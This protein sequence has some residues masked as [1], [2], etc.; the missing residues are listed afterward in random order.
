MFDRDAFR[1]SQISKIEFQ[2][3]IIFL[4]PPLF[5]FAFRRFNF[6]LLFSWFHSCVIRD[7]M[8]SHS[9]WKKHN[10]VKTIKMLSFFH[11]YMILVY[12]FRRNIFIE[13]SVFNSSS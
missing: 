11:F 3:L 2:P 10:E 1:T 7:F 4:D 6:S 13:W 12:F 5:L 8:V 9:Y